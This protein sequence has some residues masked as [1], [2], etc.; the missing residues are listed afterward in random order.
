MY[1]QVS[2]AEA[3]SLFSQTDITIADVRDVDSF[4]AG[5]IPK[6]VHLSVSK[7]QDFC[8]HHDKSKPLLIYCYHGISSQSV[9]QHLVDQGFQ[10]VYSLTG[11]FEGWKTHQTE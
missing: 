4:E 2:L 10:D 8:D 6:A 9:A 11:G 7:L 3:E 5:H 1:K